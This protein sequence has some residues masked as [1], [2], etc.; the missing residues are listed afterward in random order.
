MSTRVHPEKN[1]DFSKV[2]DEDKPSD[3]QR[4]ASPVSPSPASF[5]LA[6]Q[7]T[8]R[9]SKRRLYSLDESE[10]GEQAFLRS[11]M[12]SRSLSARWTA[13]KTVVAA[14][15]SGIEDP[16]SPTP[17]QRRRAHPAFRCVHPTRSRRLLRA[18]L[19][20]PPVLVCCLLPIAG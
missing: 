16:G 2:A 9:L 1:S 15:R 20:L 6:R 5:S 12:I 4:S 17:A 3:D 7:L 11:G 19:P 18:L 14:Q 10:G 8:S 13:V